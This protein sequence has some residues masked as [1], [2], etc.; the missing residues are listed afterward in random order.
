MKTFFSILAITAVAMLVAVP[1]IAQGPSPAPIPP[2]F[3]V[4]WVINMHSANANGGSGTAHYYIATPS[5][6]HMPSPSPIQ[7]TTSKL[8]VECEYLTFPDLTTLDVFVGPGRSPREPFGTLV[9]T[10]QVKDGTANWLSTRPPV[11]TKGTTI[12]VVREGM[13]VMRGTF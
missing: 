10:M 9:G 12:T 8:S 6:H 4:N 13:P 2:G 1:A 5:I 7:K 11:V 3:Y